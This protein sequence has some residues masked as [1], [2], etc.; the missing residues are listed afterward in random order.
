[1]TLP[2]ARFARRDTSMR[3][4]RHGFDRCDRN[5]HD[6]SPKPPVAGAKISFG[7]CSRSRPCAHRPISPCALFRS[8]SSRMCSLQLWE[9]TNS[10]DKEPYRDGSK[11]WFPRNR[12]GPVH[13]SSIRYCAGRSD[14]PRVEY[15][16]A[17]ACPRVCRKSATYRS[18]R[19]HV[20]SPGAVGWHNNTLAKVA[21]ATGAHTGFRGLAP[22]H[23]GRKDTPCK[24]LQS[25]KESR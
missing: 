5:S 6:S 7:D 3:V 21:F 12:T 24:Y 11:R 14:T 2:N 22:K 19:S 10:L 23:V 15:R 20:G 4:P 25:S 13:N 8:M 16:Q 9:L 18:H 17:A 1:M